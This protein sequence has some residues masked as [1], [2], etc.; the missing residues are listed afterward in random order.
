MGVHVKFDLPGGSVLREGKHLILLRVHRIDTLKIHPGL[1]V[2]QGDGD[3]ALIVQRVLRDGGGG[4]VQDVDVGEFRGGHA[5]E[6]LD[7]DLQDPVGVDGDG[8]GLAA[9]LLR[10]HRLPVLGDHQILGGKEGADP[11]GG[12]GGEVVLRVPH[13]DLHLR[14]RC[15]QVKNDAV[16][17]NKRK[18]VEKENGAQVSRISLPS[19]ASSGLLHMMTPPDDQYSVGAVFLE[20]F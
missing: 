20:K 12:R 14:F 7:G 11:H 3:D 19:S 4:V 17:H 9:K 8:V 2:R 18:N 6:I 1:G 16:Y 13:G 15:E 10:V 5:V